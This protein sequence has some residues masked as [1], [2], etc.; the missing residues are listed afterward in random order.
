MTK[1]DQYKEALKDIQT[2]KGLLKPRD[3]VDEAVNEDNPLHDYFDWDDSS[4]G[5]KHR[6]WQA[7]QLIKTIRVEVVG[8]QTEAYHNVV[9]DLEAVPTQGYYPIEKILLS[10]QLTRQIIISALNEIEYWMDKYQHLKQLE[11]L[12]NQEKFNQ[13]KMMF[14]LER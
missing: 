3:V 14:N 10:E 8:K 2:R 9:V 1:H 13:L 7:R 5:D 6:L 11:G 12:I 4:A